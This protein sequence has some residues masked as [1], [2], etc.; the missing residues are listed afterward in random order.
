MM[1]INSIHKVF[2]LS[3][4]ILMLGACEGTKSANDMSTKDL[5]STVSME[6]STLGSSSIMKINKKEI[7][8]SSQSRGGEE[9]TSTR[10]TVSKNWN[11]I[12][13]LVSNLDL[14]EL[15]NWEAPTGARLYDGAK[16]TMVSIVVNGKTYVSQPFDEGNPPAG[17]RELYD[18]LESLVNQ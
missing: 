14:N 9:S 3:I 10:S 4:I 17:L 2:S 5:V 12:N 6:K 13:R 1:I 11:E 15:A 16:A 8:V 18:Y 7:T